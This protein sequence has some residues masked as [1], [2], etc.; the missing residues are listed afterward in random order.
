MVLTEEGEM[1][2]LE[3]LLVQ[4]LEQLKIANQLKRLELVAN[5]TTDEQFIDRAMEIR[6]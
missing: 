1:R 6:T 2:I 3:Q 5:S 4:I